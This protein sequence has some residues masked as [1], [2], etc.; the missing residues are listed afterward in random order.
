MNEV[1]LSVVLRYSSA[2]AFAPAID[3]VQQILDAAIATELLNFPDY[4]NECQGAKVYGAPL[5]LCYLPDIITVKG[6]YITRHGN[7][8][9]IDTIKPP[10]TNTGTEYRAVGRVWR[11]FRGK[12][13]P[14]MPNMWH[15]SGRCDGSRESGKDIVGPWPGDDVMAPPKDGAKWLP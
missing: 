14:R 11:L 2:A 3:R 7:K 15:V 5:Y 9:S 10:G 12:M 8:V 4:Q 1:T 6:D 13:R